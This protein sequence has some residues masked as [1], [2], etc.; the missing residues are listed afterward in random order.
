MIPEK[1]HDKADAGIAAEG[2]NAVQR[3][4][5][6]GPFVFI[7]YFTSFGAKTQAPPEGKCRFLISIASFAMRN[8][9]QASPTM[10][11]P[12]LRRS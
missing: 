12:S 2:C 5:V 11:P 7:L 1:L 10:R 9:N 3:S 6:W 4:Y 8:Q